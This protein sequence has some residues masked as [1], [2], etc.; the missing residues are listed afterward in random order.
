GAIVLL[1]I[2][3]GPARGLVGAACPPAATEVS[4][5]W[6]AARA[7]GRA[8]YPAVAVRQLWAPTAA[9]V[10]MV[11]LM[12]LVR[13]AALWTSVPLGALAYGLGALLLLRRKMLSVS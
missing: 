10:I 11:A 4:R 9:A 2:V 5:L 6:L 3:A 12:L 13:P 1:A 8:G 7:A